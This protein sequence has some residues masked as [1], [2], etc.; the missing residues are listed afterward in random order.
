MLKAHP[1]RLVIGVIGRGHMEL[2]FGAP[3]QLK[4]LGVVDVSVLL[5]HDLSDAEPPAGLAHCVF[6]L[7]DVTC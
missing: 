3:D 6:V 2:G 7:D 4:D 1:D 5:P